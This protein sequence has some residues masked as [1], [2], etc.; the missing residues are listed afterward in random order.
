MTYDYSPPP[1]PPTDPVPPERPSGRHP[2]NIGRLVM[3]LVFLSF[4]VVWALIET[5]TVDIRDV[6]DVRL[7]LPLP[8]IVGGAAGLLAAVLRAGRR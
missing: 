4:V 8:F 1:P 3:G 2:V 6:H 5:R 7:L